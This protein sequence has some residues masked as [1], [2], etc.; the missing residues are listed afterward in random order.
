[1]FNMFPFPRWVI[2]SLLSL[3]VCVM[4]F[5]L[6]SADPRPHEVVRDVSGSTHP[7]VL[8]AVFARGEHLVYTAKL[9]EVPA[10]ESAIRL[11]KERQNGREVYRA[12]LQGR[13]SEWID[14]LYRLRGT[15]EGT[16]TANG[17]TPLLFHLTYTDNDRLRELGVRYDPAA[18][19][20][21]GSVKRRAQVKERRVPAQGVY[22]P[23]TAFYL[24]RSSDLPLGKPFQVEVFTGKERYRIVM[25]VVRNEEVLLASGVRPAIRLHPAVF[26]LDDAPQENLLPQATT[27]WVT[28]DE[29]RAPL[30][31]ESFLPVGVLVIELSNG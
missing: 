23:I 9:N 31:L 8:P 20:L 4:A 22:D 19:T 13:S 10:G 30:K 7:R 25:Q 28:A 11:R 14:Y 16:F 1:M 21:L 12:T 17:F 15:A 3:A 18:R 2:V 26:S 5:S 29:T 27:V 6:L 24:L